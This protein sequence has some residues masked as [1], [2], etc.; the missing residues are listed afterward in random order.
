LE[1]TTHNHLFPMHT[2]TAFSCPSEILHSQFAAQ[3]NIQTETE[4]E[5]S[6]EP[7]VLLEVGDDLLERGADVLSAGP[8]SQSLYNDPQGKQVLQLTLQGPHQLHLG[9]QL[10]A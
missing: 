10:D 1:V 8:K 4:T 2:H 7:G 3:R 5:N 9:I 6:L